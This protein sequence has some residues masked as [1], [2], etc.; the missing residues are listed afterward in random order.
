MFKYIFLIIG[1]LIMLYGC[2]YKSNPVYV[3]DNSEIQK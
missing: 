3:D 2:G 1:M